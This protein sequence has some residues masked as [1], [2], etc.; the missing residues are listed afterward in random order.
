MNRVRGAALLVLI[1]AGL[2]CGPPPR[3]S[4]APHDPLLRRT[5]PFA[6]NGLVDLRDWNF[7]RDGM[8]HLHGDWEFH[9]K[10][11]LPPTTGQVRAPEKI[12]PTQ[13]LH[14]PRQWGIGREGPQEKF[15]YGTYRLTLLLNENAPRRLYVYSPE[16]RCAYTL[17]ANNTETDLPIAQAGRVGTDY[18]SAIPLLMNTTTS[19]TRDGDILVFTMHVACYIASGGGTFA[20]PLLGMRD[21]VQH[22]RERGIAIDLFLAGGLMIIGLYHIVLFGQRRKDA[23]PLFLGLVSCLLSLRV[24]FTGERIGVD[25]LMLLTPAASPLS[26]RF[27]HFTAYAGILLY[28]WFCYTALSPGRYKTAI[29]ILTFIHLPFIFATIGLPLRYALSL[30]PY[31]VPV[32]LGGSVLCTYLISKAWHGESGARAILAGSLLLLLTAIHDVLLSLGYITGFHQASIGLLIMI[33]SQAVVLARRYSR[34]YEIAGQLSEDLEQ[35]VEKRTRELQQSN[36]DL[37]DARDAAESANRAKSEFVANMSH[38]IRTPMNAILGFTSILVEQIRD[39]QHRD[40]LKT[41]SSSGRLLLKLINDILD[42][43]RIEAGRLNLEYA[44]I[45]V[46]E[47]L[48]EL[49]R[50][51][52]HTASN[53]GVDFEVQASADLPAILYLDEV[54]LR[55]VLLNLIGN[56][57]KF[58]SKGFVRVSAYIRPQENVPEETDDPTEQTEERYHLVL[59]VQDSGIG[60]SNQGQ[61][62]IFEAFNQAHGETQKYGGV[63]LGLT[64]SR[65]LLEMMGGTIAVIS[66]A[67]RGSQFLVDLP[68][69]RG[70]AVW[71]RAADQDETTDATTP[72]HHLRFT[73]ARIL[74]AD[75]LSTNRQLLRKY[76]ETQ[77]FDIVEVDNGG[78]AVAQARESRP[79]LILM[80]IKMPVLGGKEATR[81]LKDDPATR[82]IPVIAVTASVLAGMADDIRAL[83]DGFLRKP[84]LKT[85]L[86]RELKRFLKYEADP[87]IAT[88]SEIPAK[89]APEPFA[90]STAQPAANSAPESRAHPELLERLERQ[91]PQWEEIS[92]TKPITAIIEFAQATNAIGRRYSHQATI[93]WA[94]KLQAAGETFEVDQ[95]TILLLDYPK[96]ITHVRAQSQS[97]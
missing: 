35:Q 14:V 69:V 4:D 13:T 85:D 55:Q 36:L 58:T 34:S 73:P 78:A 20:P 16:Q 70:H 25:I 54:R 53:N 39:P 72:D 76:L 67:G 90:Y 41:I 66:T 23:A 77:P 81:M 9:W 79:D 21:Q 68:N 62:E 92:R 11:L 50:L 30:V 12:E 97:S 31:Y 33:L 18:A 83:C 45:D 71:D 27:M 59:S 94:E 10:E 38:E 87:D 32:L 88:P 89:I 61:R 3:Y 43:S 80:D 2:M 56:A 60:I 19:F 47:I 96:L 95:M 48:E 26:L 44:P 8:V 5:S 17:Y 49:R 1:S 6:R 63:G 52:R 75:D 65:R 7:A 84:V 46:R 29:R 51:F 40:Y 91:L 15:G 57:L 64:I 74:I 37:Q 82:E 93:E 86:I 22:R 42:L 28:F 24:L